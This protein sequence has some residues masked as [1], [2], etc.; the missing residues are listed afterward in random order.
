MRARQVDA[1]ELKRDAKP[2]M[3]AERLKETDLI[4]TLGGDGTFLAG[5]RVAAP[6]DIAVL[7][8]NHGHLG[9]LTEIEAE[10]MD[11]GLGRFFDGSYRIE[12]RT[13]LEVTQS[14]KGRTLIQEIGLNE[15][16]VDHSGETNILR[17]E[18][19]SGGQRVGVIDPNCTVGGT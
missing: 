2:E 1:V 10:E 18:V 3:V 9:F 7:G 5:A 16:V 14:R 8:V 6:R 4:L 15:V 11:V 13:M 17:L 12:E 19:G